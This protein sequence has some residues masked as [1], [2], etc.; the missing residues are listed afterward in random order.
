MALAEHASAERFGQFQHSLD[1]VLHHAAH[2]NAGPIAHDRGHC[3]LIHGRQNQGL[4][5]LQLG[6]RGLCRVH[7]VQPGGSLG[8]LRVFPQF[9][10]QVENLVHQLL[11]LCPTLLQ[12]G[13]SLL[14]PLHPVPG[15][16][17]PTCGVAH[18]EGCLSPNDFQLSL[19]RLDAA[20]AVLDLGRHR[21]LADGDPG[22]GGVEQTDRLVGQ[23]AG[24]N[25][26]VG[27][28]DRRLQ[29][30]VEHENPMVLF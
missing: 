8:R 19:E 9:A 17:L 16:L 13:Q 27:Q 26:A 21:V 25:V 10:P 28:L 24:R 3:L 1:L 11:F 20:A 4:L 12:T 15:N 2:R 29:R 18:P 7:F 6:Q 22:T 5:A 14:F 30:L 23:L